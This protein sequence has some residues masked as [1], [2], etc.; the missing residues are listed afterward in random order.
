MYGVRVPIVWPA[1]I[2]NPLCYL[3]NK[4][5][6]LTRIRV[7][8]LPAAGGVPIGRVGERAEERTSEM[9]ERLEEAT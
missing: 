1:A 4:S 6:N 5:T 8:M 3:R 9:Q 2:P 7:P